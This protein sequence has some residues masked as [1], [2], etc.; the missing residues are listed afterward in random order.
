MKEAF[1]GKVVGVVVIVLAGL[2]SIISS[3]VYL[4]NNNK[5]NSVLEI[6][7]TASV[8]IDGQELGKDIL[9]KADVSRNS[10]IKFDLVG[11]TIE[12]RITEVNKEYIIIE[13]NY[14]LYDSKKGENSKKYKIKCRIS[15]RSFKTG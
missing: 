5:D 12:F 9:K 6:T 8:G 7:H 4:K 14:E 1:K 10:L 13:S 2:L 15:S 3:V 11:D